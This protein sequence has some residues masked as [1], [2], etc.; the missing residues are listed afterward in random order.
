[1]SNYD[2]MEDLRSHIDSEGLEYFF[3]DYTDA[4][5]ITVDGQP[6]PDHIVQAARDLQ[7]ARDTLSNYFI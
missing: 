6:L 1:M 7:E 3:C 2:S 5:T 4:D